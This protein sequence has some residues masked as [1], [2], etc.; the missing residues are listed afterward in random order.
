MD[1][2]RI[3]DF[4]RVRTTNSTDAT[5]PSRVPT[6]TEPTGN[7]VVEMAAIAGEMP[8]HLLMVPYATGPSNATFRSRMIGWRRLLS[9]TGVALWLPVILGEFACTLGTTVGVSGGAIS[10]GERM[11]DTL[12]LNVGNA[13]VS[14]EVVSPANDTIAHAVIDAKGFA[15][16]E[17]LFEIVAS[18]TDMNALIARL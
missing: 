4:T 9:T 12:T 7:G 18:T 11:V 14:V 6:L 2:T 16:L 1:L 5:Y 8:S 3:S 17:F 15:K 10:T 13:N